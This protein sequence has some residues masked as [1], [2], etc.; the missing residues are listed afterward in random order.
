LSAP[1]FVSL[2]RFS[3]YHMERLV[4]TDWVATQSVEGDLNGDGIPGP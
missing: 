1:A 2:P 3:V 4:P